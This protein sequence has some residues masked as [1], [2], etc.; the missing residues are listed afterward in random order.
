M[1]ERRKPRCSPHRKPITHPTPRRT[2]ASAS[3]SIAP[4]Q[5][6]RSNPGCDLAKKPCD[7]A[8]RICTRPNRICDRSNGTCSRA[9]ELCNAAPAIWTAAPKT[10]A[11][12]P[13]KLRPSKE[14]LRPSKS[15]LRG[16]TEKVQRRTETLRRFKSTVREANTEA[17]GKFQKQKSR[18]TALRVVALGYCFPTSPTFLK[19]CSARRW[20][21]P[22]M[23]SAMCLAPSTIR[24]TLA[25]RRARRPF[26]IRL[27]TAIARSAQ[28]SK[29]S[30]R[31]GSTWS[32]RT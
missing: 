16:S 8:N 5:C 13:R 9:N 17:V 4:I 24:I 27:A 28:D 18:I 21:S 32:Q 6:N 31:N 14:N 3:S 2:R 20:I 23:N 1:W 19:A 26:R 22:Y 11:A 25:Q 10:C 30:W 12:G 15:D 7:R 29:R